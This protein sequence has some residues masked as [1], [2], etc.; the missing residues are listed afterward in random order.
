MSALAGTRQEPSLAHLYLTKFL[1]FLAV[2]F[3]PPTHYRV[4]SSCLSFYVSFSSR[5]VSLLSFYLAIIIFFIRLSKISSG[6]ICRFMNYHTLIIIYSYLRIFI[7]AAVAFSS[8]EKA[9]HRRA[10]RLPKIM[11]MIFE[12]LFCYC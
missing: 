4:F 12:Y 7:A 1:F 10:R 2:S 6:S 9:Y 8:I 3:Y 11:Y 5:F